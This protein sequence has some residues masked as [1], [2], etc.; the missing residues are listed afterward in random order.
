MGTLVQDIRYAVRLLI[1]GPGFTVAAVLA[2]TLGIGANTAIFTLVNGLL[3]RPMPGISDLESL[4]GVGRTTDG[5][6]FDTLSYPDY[7]DYRNQAGSLEEIA[8]TRR[9]GMTLTTGGSSERITGALVSGNYFQALGTESAL[10]RVLAPID[11]GPPGENPVVVL[12][13]RLWQERLGGDPNAIGQTITLNGYPLVVIGVTEEG[14]RGTQVLNRVEAWVP[15]TMQPQVMSRGFELISERGAV[16][17]TAFGRLADGVSVE[18][19]R[20]E[21]TGIAGRLE[22][23]YPESN[24]GRG[25]DVV[26]GIGLH[27]RLRTD[28]RNSSAVLMVVVLFVLLIAAANIANLL[29]ARAIARQREMGIR[30]AIGASR[31]RLLRQLMVESTLLSLLGGGGGLVLTIWGTDLLRMLISA[32]PLSSAAG[33]VDLQIDLRILGFT[34]AVSLLTGFVFGLAPALSA[35]RARVTDTLKGGQAGGP[36]SRSRFRSALVV[37]QLALSLVLLVAAGLFTRSLGNFRNVDPGTDVE[38][39]AVVGIELNEEDYPE[40]EARQFFDTLIDRIGRIPGVSGAG[41]GHP[42][43][44][45]GSRRS[46]RIRVP[47]YSPPDGREAFSADYRI[48]SPGYFRTM[49]IPLISGR[50]MAGRTATGGSWEIIVNQTAAQRFWPGANPLGQQIQFLVGVNPDRYADA[51]VVGV[52][53]DVKYRSL[54][55]PPQPHLYVPFSQDFLWSM[56]LHIR[57]ESDPLAVAEAVRDQVTAMDANLP[58][59]GFRTLEEQLNLSIGSARVAATLAGLFALLAAIL[60]ALGLY[61]AL[62]HYVRHRTHEIGVRMALGAES[63]LVLGLIVR[64]GLRLVGYGMVIGIGIAIAATRVLESELYGVSPTDP[65]TFISVLLL[66]SSVALLAAWLPA[67]RATRVDPVAALRYE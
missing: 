18:Q 9:V 11:E 51:T 13:H 44:L 65:L 27:P 49:G 15:I 31:L 54:D 25:I 45:S 16:W 28:I 35:S 6:G 58:L 1:K 26:P 21:L 38:R 60:A 39:V 61:G 19:A 17:M 22:Q 47:G 20:A 63:G 10:G 23:T 24:Q 7:L 53:R 52:A 66:L 36:I 62:S 42:V 5:S 50:T 64:Q 3:L 8:A 41:L 34:L 57:S 30:M 56:S 4:I 37:G 2:L 55:E 43:Q 46:S 40:A 14:F 33:I 29:L 48:V 32:T 67:R 59:I 12:G